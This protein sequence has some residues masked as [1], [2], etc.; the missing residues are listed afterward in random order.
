MRIFHQSDDIYSEWFVIHHRC[1]GSQL[2]P[3]Y[4]SIHEPQSYGGHCSG[5]S[6]FQGKLRHICDPRHRP[7]YEGINGSHLCC[8]SAINKFVG[9]R[10]RPVQT[11]ADFFY[12]RADGLFSVQ[13]V[14]ARKLTGKRGFYSQ[15]YHFIPA[16]ITVQS[17]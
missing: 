10:R 14:F 8:H 15:R 5:L 3:E 16:K 6:H 9:K 4:V 11:V 2:L 1:Q 13:S 7:L 17:V 12:E